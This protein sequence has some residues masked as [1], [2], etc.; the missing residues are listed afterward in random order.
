MNNSHITQNEWVELFSIRNRDKN[1]MLLQSRIMEHINECAECRE[2]YG[3][4]LALQEASMALA[5]STGS[6]LN[7]DAAFQAVAS[8][9]KPTR[10]PNQ[11]QGHLYICLDCSLSGATFVEDTL[12][13]EGYANRYALNLEEEGRCLLDD[14]GALRLE[15]QDDR[16]IVA[17]ESGEPDCV[18]HLMP[19]GSDDCSAKVTAGRDASIP[20]PSDDFC[21]L[22]IVF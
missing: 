19:E 4:G 16:L 5:A 9:G 2:F 14:E 20:L 10:N 21:T 17:L 3:K 12:E 13:Q 7:A 18:C 22:E 6:Q 11:V 15:L 1:W 8:T